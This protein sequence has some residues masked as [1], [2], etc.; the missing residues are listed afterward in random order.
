MTITARGLREIVVDGHVYV[1]RVRKTK[2][3]CC[4]SRAVVISDASRRG[5]VV[6]LPG[7][8]PLS[9]E[10]VAITPR[11]IAERAREARALGWEP[12]SGSGV[13]VVLA[14]AAAKGRTS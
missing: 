12:G 4:R 11:L 9:P 5:S 2:C 1:W 13:F 10:T 3:P 6:H 7:P 8:D 14:P